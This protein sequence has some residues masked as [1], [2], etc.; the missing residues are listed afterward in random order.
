MKWQQVIKDIVEF[1]T[2]LNLW[3][4]TYDFDSVNLEIPMQNWI[5]IVP[6]IC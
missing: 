2:I 6:I 5:V 4:H 3:K 1:P